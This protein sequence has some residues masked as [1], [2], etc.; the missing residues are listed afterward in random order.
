M[1][2]PLYVHLPNGSPVPRL[3]PEPFIVLLIAESIALDD[4]RAQVCGDLARSG[5]HSFIAWGQ[6]CVQ[7]CVEMQKT[8]ASSGARIMIAAH[9]DE[10][11][12][13]AMWAS[14]HGA[15]HPEVTLQALVIVHV[16]PRERREEI[17]FQFHSAAMREKPGI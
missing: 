9:E 8:T 5:C 10:P 1:P 13:E 7:W 11:L 3:G 17:L 6:D 2:A 14:V 16:T 4:W 15:D 12:A